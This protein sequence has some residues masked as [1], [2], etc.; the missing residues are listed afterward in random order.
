MRGSTGQSIF[1]A[2]L[3][4]SQVS[5]DYSVS[6]EKLF[7]KMLGAFGIGISFTDSHEK[8]FEVP[9]VQE[10]HE[11]LA[12]Q[13]SITFFTEYLWVAGTLCCC[14]VLCDVL[15]AK[16]RLVESAI[17]DAIQQAWSFMDGSLTPSKPLS[18][19]ELKTIL[20]KWRIWRS[21]SRKAQT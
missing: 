9:S 6:V 12:G 8:L 1:A 20:R 16:P 2:E 13:R 10:L 18:D 17:V 3:S 5:P 15:H 14:A 4:N 11:I 7:G 19:S 21:E